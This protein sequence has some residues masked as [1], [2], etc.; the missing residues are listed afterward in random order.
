M[1]VKGS[2]LVLKLEQNILGPFYAVLI[3]G[4]KSRRGG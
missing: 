3:C 4:I 1:M 2:L